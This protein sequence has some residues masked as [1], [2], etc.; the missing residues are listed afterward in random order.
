MLSLEPSKMF[1]IV[2]S[3]M[4][5]Q[6]DSRAK[7]ININLKRS[8]SMVER[9]RESR[10]KM[11]NSHRFPVWSEGSD[12]YES[13]DSTQSYA[14]SLNSEQLSQINVWDTL[15]RCNPNINSELMIKTCVNAFTEQFDKIV[16]NFDAI[17]QVVDKF[18]D[19]TFLNKISS[20]IG[21]SNIGVS[22]QV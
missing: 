3:T 15:I 21:E 6:Y 9:Q 20:F 10:Q 8:R 19:S 4:A 13:D 2:S 16:D 14:S 12:G 18:F 7:N 22:V 5:N 11:F 1:V 17:T